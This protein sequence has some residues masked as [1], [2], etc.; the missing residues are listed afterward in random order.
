M[1]SRAARRQI[2]LPSTLIDERI[3]LRRVPSFAHMVPGEPSGGSAGYCRTSG[4]VNANFFF[5]TLGKVA[6]RAALS[7]HVPVG[8]WAKKPVSS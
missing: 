3:I 2:P 7:M 5:W 4:Y 8:V 1:R 6:A